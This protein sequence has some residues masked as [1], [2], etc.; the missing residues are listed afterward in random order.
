[1]AGGDQEFVD[2]VF[3]EI[4]KRDAIA[5][6]KQIKA[7]VDDM[8]E[9]EKR[10]AR[11]DGAAAQRRRI[12]AAAAAQQQRAA[13][14]AARDAARQ[15]TAAS[16]RMIQQIEGMRAAYAAMSTVFRGAYSAAR[17]LAEYSSDIA[18]EYGELESA[19]TGFMRALAD[20]VA[21][22]GGFTDFINGLTDSFRELAP[23]ARNAGSNVSNFVGELRDWIGYFSG[24][25]LGNAGAGTREGMVDALRRRQPG[26]MTPVGDDYDTGWGELGE[27]ANLPQ[28][29]P[30]QE[31][32]DYERGGVLASGQTVLPQDSLGSQGVRATGRGGRGRAGG[33][34]GRET[35]EYINDAQLLIE[36][37]N[38]AAR[39]HAEAFDVYLDDLSGYQDAILET[40]E[41]ERA[42]AEE[43]KSFIERESE[44]RERAAEEQVQRIE[45]L[46]EQ[47][48][49]YR[50][51][52]LQRSRQRI[53]DMQGYAGSFI[54][55]GGAIGDVFGQLADREEEGSEAAKR[56]GKIQGGIMAAMSFIQSAVEYAAGIGSIAT[57][58]YVAAAAHFAAGIAYD[59]AGAMAIAQ[60][61]GDATAAST[62]SSASAGTYVAEQPTGDNLGTPSGAYVQIITMGGTSARL[63]QEMLRAERDLQR[64]GLDPP[65]TGGGSW[66]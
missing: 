54:T 66:S 57:H 52:E 21:R 46:A 7:A 8:T 65:M 16:A 40:L 28:S 23:A 38:L 53:S 43:S 35:R 30:G 20:G 41:I 49:A 50:E 59:V 27:Y 32:L 34:G 18:R 15:Q 22:G 13:A 39:A 61:G 19:A 47:E 4:G 55:V 14:K 29:I 58:D 5:A 1:V 63:G 10:W 60:L 44:M 26:Y 45:E 12:A 51:E 3:R 56:Y 37:E 62:G 11:E 64:A 31:N 9:S 24:G 36:L 17:S 2:L 25:R 48:R 33:G 6:A 42:A